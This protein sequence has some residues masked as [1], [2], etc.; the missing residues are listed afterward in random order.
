MIFHPLCIIKIGW[1]ILFSNPFI[2]SRNIA[3]FLLF[4]S[5]TRSKKHLKCHIFFRCM[6]TTM[7]E[8]LY[9]F[10]QFPGSKN[11][12]EEKYFL[13][14]LSI[15]CLK[16]LWQNMAVVSTY[17]VMNFWGKKLTKISLFKDISWNKNIEK[18][19]FLLSGFLNQ[20]IG[21]NHTIVLPLLSSYIWRKYS[22]WDDFLIQ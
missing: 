7:E 11:C 2:M 4:W 19:F 17:F 15:S 13:K 20:E 16:T 14:F 6:V 5:F 10:Y 18:I 8:Q 21:R 12:W 3:K 22:F 1:E 9:G